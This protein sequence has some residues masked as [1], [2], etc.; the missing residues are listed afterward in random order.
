MLVRFQ[1]QERESYIRRH[2]HPSGNWRRNKDQPV[3]IPSCSFQ[4]CRIPL[5]VQTRNQHLSLVF[6]GICCV[7]HVLSRFWKF[8]SFNCFFSFSVTLLCD[9]VD[10]N[11]DVGLLFTVNF[12]DKSITR[13]ARIA[14][15]WGREE[16]T[17]PYFPFT[18]GDTFKVIL[19]VLWIGWKK[20]GGERLKAVCTTTG[21]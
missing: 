21:S 19:G 2:R 17:I 10:A 15:K 14:G 3:L 20:G 9:P 7:H 4:A 16:K 11:K 8:Q 13:N 18:A 6:T 5:S 12:S 1:S